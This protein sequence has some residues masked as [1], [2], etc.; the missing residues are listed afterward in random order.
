[1]IKK[2]NT[3]IPTKTNKKLKSKKH[4]DTAKTHLKKKTNK[5]ILGIT[6]NIIVED[7]GDPS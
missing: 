3:G 5:E 1:M 2:I 6:E 4:V 7:N